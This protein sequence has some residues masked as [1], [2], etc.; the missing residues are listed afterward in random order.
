MLANKR[1]GGWYTRAYLASQAQWSKRLAFINVDDPSP[2]I[3]QF[4]NCAS[5][6]IYFS[7]TRKMIDSAFKWAA[8]HG[9]TRINPTHSEEEARLVLSETFEL[10]DETGQTMEFSGTMEVEDY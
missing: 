4:K 8:S 7:H 9:L 1:D 5:M 2:A 10:C 6:C 3:I